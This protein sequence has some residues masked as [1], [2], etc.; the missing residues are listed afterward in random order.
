MRPCP[1]ISASA[2]GEF[3]TEREAAKSYDVAAREHFGDF[4]VC[5]FPPSFSCAE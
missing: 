1:E 4:A 2:L 3:G 5:N